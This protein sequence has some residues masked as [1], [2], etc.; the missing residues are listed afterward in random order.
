MHDVIELFG[1]NE[2]EATMICPIEPS[3]CMNEED[4]MNKDD[5]II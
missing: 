5:G 2:F 4:T 1:A 3:P